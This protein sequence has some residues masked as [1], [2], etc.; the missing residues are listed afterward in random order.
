[1][2]AVVSCHERPR[3]GSTKRTLPVAHAGGSVFGRSRPAEES[4]SS[5][6]AASD[7]AGLPV[8]RANAAKARSS[9]PDG[10]PGPDVRRSI[11]SDRL[12]PVLMYDSKSSTCIAEPTA[13]TIDASSARGPAVERRE[14]RQ[15]EPDA[16]VVPGQA[17]PV[18]HPIVGAPG[19]QQLR[20]VEVPEPARRRVRARVLEDPVDRAPGRLVGSLHGGQIGECLHVVRG[21]EQIR[22]G[23]HRLWPEPPGIDE[24]DEQRLG[25]G[26]EQRIDV[27]IQIPVDQVLVLEHVGA[28]H[29]QTALQL[30]PHLVPD[31]AAGALPGGLP[32][33]AGRVPVGD[34]DRDHA[35][36]VSVAEAA[37]VDVGPELCL[38]HG[39]ERPRRVEVDLVAAADGRVIV[40]VELDAVHPVR[41]LAEREDVGQARIGAHDLVGDDRGHDLDRQR[42][43]VVVRADLAHCAVVLDGHASH[44]ATVHLDRAH[45]G[46]ELVLHALSA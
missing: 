42:G 36:D 35:A 19:L 44:D 39:R 46:V 31:L 4:A 33:Q 32:I 24:I 15:P 41:V 14:R 40:E 12:S 20:L 26:L 8:V 34:D 1:M 25:V 6:D 3:Y 23:C 2:P 43:H 30:V 45:A 38:G 9:S 22:D 7:S 17:L 27:E 28:L 11:N 37:E 13:L 5:A 18:A 16:G 29:V 10:A 21:Q